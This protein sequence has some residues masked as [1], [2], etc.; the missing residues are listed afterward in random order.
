M[1]PAHFPEHS[2]GDHPA[3]AV[4]DGGEADVAAGL[5]VEAA[6]HPVINGVAAGNRRIVG[7]FAVAVSLAHLCAAAD[8]A[9]HRLQEAGVHQ[10]VRVKDAEGVVF[11]F[12]QQLVE[13]EGQHL[14]FGFDRDG[15][16]YD[17]RP[18]FSG[19]AGGVVGAVVGDDVNVEKLFGIVL[20]VQAFHQVPDDAFL[21]AGGNQH[22]KAVF[23]RAGCPGFPPLESGQRYNQIVCS[24]DCEEKAQPPCEGG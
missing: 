9:V 18:R 6:D 16:V 15:A 23:G 7:V 22:G 10:I 19:G 11:F 5:A 1:E 2:G 24:V 14:P 8:G 4:D 20:R 21:V 17:F 3:A 12:F 13:S